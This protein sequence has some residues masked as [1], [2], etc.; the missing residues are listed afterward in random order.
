M[1]DLRE[2]AID[3]WVAENVYKVAYDKK[4]ILLD[5]KRTEE[6]RKEARENRAKL[7]KPYDA[8]IKVWSKLRPPEKALNY[9][10][11]WEI[12]DCK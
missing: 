2:G 7:G 1:N 12:N 4:N 11:P 5:V 3:D 6:L 9:F 8:F 10:G